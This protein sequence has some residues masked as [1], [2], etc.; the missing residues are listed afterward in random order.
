LTDPNDIA[1]KLA[2]LNAIV[3]LKPG[4]TILVTDKGEALWN[5]RVLASGTYEMIGK[6]TRQKFTFKPVMGSAC[7][8]SGQDQSSAY[9]HTCHS[10]EK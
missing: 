6:A 4:D 2:F 5:T 10:V 3:D 1:F 8:Q 7:T 9:C